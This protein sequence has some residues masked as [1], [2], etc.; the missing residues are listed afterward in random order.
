MGPLQ[1]GL[2]ASPAL[3][4]QTG[5][6]VPLLTPLGS[7]GDGFWALQPSTASPWQAD[8]CGRPEPPVLG[9]PLAWPC[10]GPGPFSRGCRPGPQLLCAE[11]GPKASPLASATLTPLLRERPL[12][13]PSCPPPC[14]EP[15]QLRELSI[16]LCAEAMQAALGSATQRV[17]RCA[18]RS[19]L[20]LF[21]HM[22]DQSESVAKVPLAKGLLTPRGWPGQQ[23]GARA[24]GSWALGA[25]LT[26][27]SNRLSR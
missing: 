18:Q 5:R 3:R 21:F 15:S 12:L 23:G 19:L 24:A 14:Q 13:K 11:P 7:G 16:G 4:Q 9:K 2:P 17:K 1:G 6:T 25:R 22:S 8:A 20:P 26:S 27:G 10:L